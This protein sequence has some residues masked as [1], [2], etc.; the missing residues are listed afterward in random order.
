MQYSHS[1]RCLLPAVFVVAATASVAL[2]APREEPSR[3]NEPYTL[4][5]EARDVE[6]DE[7]LEV[8]ACAVVDATE[9]G[10]LAER[11]CS[12]LLERRRK[13]LA[14]SKAEVLDKRLVHK[15]FWVIDCDEAYTL[16]V[17]GV[18]VAAAD[19]ERFTRVKHA[20]HQ[21]PLHAARFCLEQ[22]GVGPEDVDVVA[23]PWNRD[24]LRARRWKYFALDRALRAKVSKGSRS[25]SSS[26]S[27]RPR[28]SGPSNRTG[29]SARSPQISRSLWA[30]RVAT[31]TGGRLSPPKDS[32]P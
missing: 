21:L 8:S 16:L 28:S 26:C 22:A 10:A 2:A 17:D 19:E 12:Y 23:Y 1:I 7:R 6:T 30:L 24:V 13:A 20:N 29:R 14:R 4:S 25:F 32:P 27:G 9:A 11:Y 3:P 5:V 15:P 31:R 18:T